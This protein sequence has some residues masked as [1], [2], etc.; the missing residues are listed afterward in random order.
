MY[1]TDIETPVTI[2][3]EGENYYF[4]GEELEGEFIKEDC[5]DGGKGDVHYYTV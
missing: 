2:W 4:S 1:D 5:I 3:K